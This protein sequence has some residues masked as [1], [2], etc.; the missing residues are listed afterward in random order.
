MLK[1]WMIGAAVGLFLAVRGTPGNAALQLPAASRVAAP[2]AR[3]IAK[4]YV[5][6]A[7][8]TDPGHVDALHRAGVRALISMVDVGEDVERRIDELG[9][10]HYYVP[11][12]D[13]LTP[14]SVSALDEATR[15]YGPQHVAI[16]CRHGVDRTGALAA[17]ALSRYGLPVRDALWLM[18]SPQPN[19]T[20]ALTRLIGPP[21]AGIPV[22]AYSLQPLGRP[23]GMKS[24]GDN[25]ARLVRS[26]VRFGEAAGQ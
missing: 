12:G 22:A 6:L 26:A 5:L 18:T 4:G 21:S 25:Y 17:V 20:A 8:P 10:R 24:E 23:Y 3:R 16:H 7:E 9:I 11:V 13:E 14:A 19:Q 1:S 15:Q 2:D